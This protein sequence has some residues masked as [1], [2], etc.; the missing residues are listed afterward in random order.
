MNLYLPFTYK[1]WLLLILIVTV[2]V[3]LGVYHEQ[4]KIFLNYMVNENTHPV[5]FVIFFMTLP[6]IG[7]PITLFLII[8]GAKFGYYTGTFLMFVCMPVHL[9]ASFLIANSY[10]RPFF[11]DGI[12]STYRIPKVPAEHAIRF[13]IVFMAVP[14]LSYTM[15][16][17]L[18][19]LS[20]VPFRHYFVIGLFING[21]MGVPVIIAGDFLRK[22]PILLVFIFIVLLAVSYASGYV[23]KW[24][25]RSRTTM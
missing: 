20:G 12:G 18:L 3:F 19:S 21:I 15:K 9:L 8:I 23:M 6:I 4:I 11:H 25:K 17:Y 7:F 22:R 2:A 16:N 5:L 14:G 24:W 10:I 13:S 1:K